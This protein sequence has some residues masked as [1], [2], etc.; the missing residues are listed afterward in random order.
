MNNIINSL[1]RYPSKFNCPCSIRCIEAYATGNNAAA[2]AAGAVSG[3]LAAKLITEQ[4]YQKSPDQLTE[5]QKQTV[6]TLSQLASDLVRD[7]IS[8]NKMIF[9]Q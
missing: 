4:L 6:S 5:V 2:G 7:F 1:C 9:K 3:E 8:G